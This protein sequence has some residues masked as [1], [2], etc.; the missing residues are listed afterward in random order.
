MT[1]ARAAPASDS[2]TTGNVFA[3][4][5]VFQTIKNDFLAAVISSNTN[6][7]VKLL[8][9]LKGTISRSALAAA[10]AAA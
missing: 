7:S 9:S 5:V 8:G 2:S 10:I 1:T 6:G 3:S 4:T